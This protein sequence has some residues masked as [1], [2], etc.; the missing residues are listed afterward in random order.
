MEIEETSLMKELVDSD[1]HVMTDA[2]H[3]TKRIGTRTQM[4]YFTKKFKRVTF[5]LQRIS[6]RIGCAVNLNFGS[7]DLYILTL[8]LRFNQFT[9]H[10]DTSTG[11]NRFKV[12]FTQFFHIH[13]DL[14]IIDCRTVIQRDKANLFTTTTGTNPSLH[15]NGCTVSFA[16]QYIYNFCSSNCFHVYMFIL[17]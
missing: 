12:F 7:L 11:R 17:R 8:S 5:L 10:T 16:F 3:G 2:E 4:S 1:R 9:V 13:N 15:V 14:N 6:S